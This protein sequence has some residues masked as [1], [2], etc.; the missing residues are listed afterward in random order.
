MDDDRVS[1][2]IYEWRF[3]RAWTGAAAMSAWGIGLVIRQPR[4]AVDPKVVIQHLPPNVCFFD[5]I[6]LHWLHQISGIFL[7]ILAAFALTK[8]FWPCT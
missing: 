7:L 8:V 6:S 3:E 4:P 2:E 5:S 1:L